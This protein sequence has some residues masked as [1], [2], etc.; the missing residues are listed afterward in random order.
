MTILAVIAALV[1]DQLF[2]EAARLR[3]LRWV[4]Q[5]LAMANQWTP[6][7]KKD[8][9]DLLFILL[10]VVGVYWL[11]G[12]VPALLLLLL[13]TAVLL[14]SLGHRGMERDGEAYIDAWRRGERAE[15]R[16][17]ASRIIGIEVSQNTPDLTRLL[18]VT[19]ITEGHQRFIAVLFW[20]LVLGP[21]GALGFRLLHHTNKH[22]SPFNYPVRVLYNAMSW[23]T[24]HLS[25][26]GFGL[27]GNMVEMMQ[28]WRS[29]PRRDPSA[30][31]HVLIAAAMGALQIK[32][33]DFTGFEDR[34]TLPIQAALGLMRRTLLLLL[35]GLAIATLFGDG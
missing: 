8:P 23:P 31:E 20:F 19:I 18:F 32:E 16:L 30:N 11:Q 22:L 10:P 28:N 7:D 2:V 15:S 25:C 35:V 4:E 17:H 3:D 5:W 26:L 34:L 1:L 12:Q 24:V 33:G 21:A 27:V 13:S 9:A 14:F 29:V 6:A